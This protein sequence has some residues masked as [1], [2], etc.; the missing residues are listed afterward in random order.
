MFTIDADKLIID[1]MDAG[2]DHVQG[3]DGREV[4]QIVMDQLP[5][6]ECGEAPDEIDADKKMHDVLTGGCPGLEMKL[7]SAEDMKKAMHIIREYIRGQW[8]NG[9]IKKG[10]ELSASLLMSLSSLHEKWW[11]KEVEKKT[12]HSPSG[13][14]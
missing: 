9:N 14:T 13:N 5:V 1:L 4:I 6:G 11:S 10:S 7:G 12:G 2:V 3:N 8:K